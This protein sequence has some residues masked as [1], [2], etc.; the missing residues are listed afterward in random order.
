MFFLLKVISFLSEY[1]AVLET[2][3]ELRTFATK[4]VSILFG[5]L[6]PNNSQ[7]QL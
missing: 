2:K 1:P 7:E 4:A 6:I 3:S 5:D